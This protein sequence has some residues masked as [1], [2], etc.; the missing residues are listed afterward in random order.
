MKLSNS[1]PTTRSA[2]EKQAQT[3]EAIANP[4]DTSILGNPAIT[5]GFVKQV[6][7]VQQLF[8]ASGTI[9]PDR[10]I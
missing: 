4:N 5:P 9:P 3:H 10:T 6:N 2:L 8:S 7:E 1:T